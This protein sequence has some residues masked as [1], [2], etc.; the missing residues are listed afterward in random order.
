MAVPPK[1]S[2]PTARWNDRREP[3]PLAEIVPKV[4]RPACR[5]TGTAVWRRR[6]TASLKRHVRSP[7]SA[8]GFP[9]P[10]EPD[11]DTAGAGAAWVSGRR[12]AFPGR[13][14]TRQ[15]PLLCGKSAS[16]IFG[17]PSEPHTRDRAVPPSPRP[18]WVYVAL[19]RGSA[20]RLNTGMADS[21]RCEGSS[22]FW[23]DGAWMAAPL[24]EMPGRIAMGRLV[25][26]FHSSSSGRRSFGSGDLG[27]LRP[28]SATADQSPVRDYPA[29]RCLSPCTELGQSG[30]EGNART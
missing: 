18:N 30:V 4:R 14:R 16:A 19:P 25:W 17:C 7:R 24:N 26:F 2:C 10:R 28:G 1:P 9:A 27:S 3:D 12:P 13:Q 15:E 23:E 21:Q 8:P 20:T 5:L 6:R 11:G 29:T 22:R